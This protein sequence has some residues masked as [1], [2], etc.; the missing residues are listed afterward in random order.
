M[1]KAELRNAFIEALREYNR[2][3][4]ISALIYDIS[5]ICFEKGYLRGEEIEK[6]FNYEVYKR[7][8]D[9]PG[10]KFKEKYWTEISAL[11]WEFLANGTI[12][13][14]PVSFEK[15]EFRLEA[16]GVTKYGK[17]WLSSEEEPIPEDLNGYLNFLKE[18][19]PEIDKVIIEYIKEAINTFKNKYVFASAVMLGAAS[20]KIIYLLTEEI[21]KVGIDPELEQKIKRALEGRSLKALLDSFLETVEWLISEK[22][23]SREI[24]EGS[25]HYFST[26][27]DAIRIQRN[28]AV[29]PIAG[30]VSKDQVRLLLMAFPH[31]CKKAYDILNWLKENKE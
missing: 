18:N 15:D 22:R 9:I 8:E 1:E 6:N 13:I 12:S 23:I 3:N 19:I 5:L 24:H 11:Y 28:D 26:L 4:N 25:Q 14:L 2:P 30:E 20:E 29:H 16:F 10:K 31:A 7:K 17:Q 21:I 27:F